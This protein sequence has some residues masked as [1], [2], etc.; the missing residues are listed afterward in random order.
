MILGIPVRGEKMNLRERLDPFRPLCGQRAVWR[1]DF[2]PLVDIIERSGYGVETLVNLHYRREDLQVRQVLLQGLFHPIK[3]DKAGP[4][5]A[6]QMYLADG[7]EIAQATIH[8]YPLLLDAAGVAPRLT[9]R[10]RDGI[11]ATARRVVEALD[12]GL[13]PRRAA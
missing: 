2:F 10:V 8:H 5:K 4:G 1:A 11:Q 12:G 6:L 13:A 7:L 3:T 9:W